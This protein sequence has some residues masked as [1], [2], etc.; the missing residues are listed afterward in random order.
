MW[1]VSGD[2][3]DQGV[4]TRIDPTTSEM[5]GERVSLVGRPYDITTGAGSVW[6]VNN[7]QGS[8]TRLLPQ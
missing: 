2:G 3:T 1:M 7:S 5:I 4:L 6:I 8:V